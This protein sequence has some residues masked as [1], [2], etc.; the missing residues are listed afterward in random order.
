[1]RLILDALSKKD[2]FGL[3]ARAVDRTAV[4]GYAKVIKRPMD[5]GTMQRK[6]AQHAYLSL[7]AFWEDAMLVSKNA[8]KF[9]APGAAHHA[10]AQN[11]MAFT[12]QLKE[13]MASHTTDVTTDQL[14]G[15]LGST[16]AVDATYMR[17]RDNEEACFMY[18]VIQQT[19]AVVGDRSL[20]EQKG[21]APV[22]RRQAAV[23]LKEHE[24]YLYDALQLAK[25]H[26]HA[27]VFQEACA[28]SI[29]C[30]EHWH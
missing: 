6:L 3:F 28:G 12:L 11:L 27:R 5:F 16:T 8:V 14:A 22:E 13:L 21:G 2:C 18:N 10:A 26:K 24:R 30:G 29:R 25:E 23:S 19:A 20:V 4:P 7:A 15:M 9:N 17:T 1:M